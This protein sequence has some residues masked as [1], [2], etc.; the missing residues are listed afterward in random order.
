[1]EMPCGVTCEVRL[2]LTDESFQLR[3]WTYQG[4][5][6]EEI[7]NPKIESG[8]ESEG[9]GGGSILNVGQFCTDSWFCLVVLAKPVQGSLGR[10]GLSQKKKINKKNK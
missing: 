7:R 5:I 4:N 2:H 10:L 1:M 3:C 9:G 8:R 6:L